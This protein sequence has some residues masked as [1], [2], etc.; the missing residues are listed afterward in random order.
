MVQSR[1]ESIGQAHEDPYHNCARTIED[2]VKTQQDAGNSPTTSLP[3]R[4]SYRP[5]DP[6]YV[7]QQ[8]VRQAASKLHWQEHSTKITQ[9]LPLGESLSPTKVVA[10]CPYLYAVTGTAL[11]YELSQQTANGSN[12]DLDWLVRK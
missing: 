9:P 2:T 6:Q 3:E 11:R 4:G 12:G 1:S 10:R 7:A 8:Q 5:T